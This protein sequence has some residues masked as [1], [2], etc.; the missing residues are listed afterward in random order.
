MDEKREKKGAAL[1][2]KDRFGRA[3]REEK[4]VGRVVP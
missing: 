2:T 4:K 3:R 1:K